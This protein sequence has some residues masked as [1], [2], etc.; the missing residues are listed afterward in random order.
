MPVEPPKSSAAFPPPVN[1]LRSLCPLY[2]IDQR[3]WPEPI[4]SGILLAIGDERFVLTCAHVTDL[5][6]AKDPL[7]VHS[8]ING[9]LNPLRGEGCVTKSPESGREN[10]RA[11]V[12]FFRL[13]PDI[14]NGLAHQLVF[15]PIEQ[16]ALGKA[17]TEDVHYTFSGYPHR[18]SRPRG[19]S[20]LRAD[21]LPLTAASY[22]P[23]DYER[24]GVSPFRHLGIKLDGGQLRHA[25]GEPWTSTPQ[26]PT[27]LNGLSGGAVWKNFFRFMQGDPVT[28][29]LIGLCMELPPQYPES[30]LGVRISLALEGI[31]MR[32]PHL[33]H[34]IPHDPDL[35]F[36]SR[37]TPA[38]D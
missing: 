9:K 33:S 17:A 25:S 22:L 12:A 16:V 30:F 29:L 35:S 15:W 36:Y 20:I 37:Y 26:F 27:M 34:L 3:G 4:G 14:A 19:R 8:F 10:D 7:T 5:I 6:P 31:R 1:P 13:L 32:F 11:D 18:D 38:T 23:E 2:I 21:P 24:V 28:P